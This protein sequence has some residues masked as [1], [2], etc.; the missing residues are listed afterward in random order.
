MLAIVFCIDAMFAAASWR[1]GTRALAL[2]AR[3]AR[4]SRWSTASS[5]SPPAWTPRSCPRSRG[6]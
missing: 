4:T 1:A 2:L 6:W 5:W 3:E